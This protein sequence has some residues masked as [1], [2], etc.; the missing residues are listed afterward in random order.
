MSDGIKKKMTE[1]ELDALVD[2]MTLAQAAAAV[3]AV[4]SL[5]N[6]KKQGKLYGYSPQEHQVAI[7]ADKHKIVDIRGGNRCLGGEQLIY[8]PVLKAHRRVD[9]IEEDFHVMAW[10]GYREV[11]AKA[12]RPFQKAKAELY[13]LTFDDG[14]E[15]VVSPHHLLWG[16]SGWLECRL[17]VE[18][19]EVSV[20]HPASNWGTVPSV[21]PEDVEHSTCIT[22]GSRSYYRSHQHFCGGQLHKALASGPNTRPLQDDVLKHMPVYGLNLNFEPSDDRGDEPGYI[23]FYQNGGLLPSWDGPLHLLDLCAGIGSR[24]SCKLCGLAWG[25][26]PAFAQRFLGLARQPQSTAASGQQANHSLLDS[27]PCLG[28]NRQLSLSIPLDT[29]SNRSVVQI[30]YLRND[31]VWDFEVERYHNYF[32]GSILSHNSGKSE[33]SAYTMACHITGIY[34]SW[35]AGLTFSESFIYGVVS[36]STEQ[37]RKS[38]Q[39]KL[40]G[41]PHELGTG[42]IPKDLI[43]DYA[44]R[45]GTNGCLDWVLV[46]HASGGICRIEFMVCEQ[47]P[48]KFQGFAWKV[49]WF[50]EKPALPVFTEVQMRLIDNKGFIILSYFPSDDEDG[51][52]EMLDNMPADFCSHYEFH[53]EDNKT[54]DP[55]EIEMH[56]KTMPLWMQESRLYGRT[57]SGEGRI[58]TFNR[59]DYSVDPFEIEPMA[60]RIAGMDVGMAHG[61]AAVALALE[62]LSENEPPTIYVY[63]EYLRNGNLPGA[64]AI[65]LRSWGDIEFKIDPHSN[66]RSFS[67]GQRL[68]DMYREEGINV[69]KANAKPGSVLDS[70]NMINQA[71]AENR[72]YIFSS[73]RELLKQMGMYKMVKSKDG[74]VKVTEKNDDLVDCL[75]YAMMALDQAKS[76]GTTKITPMPRVAEW[77]PVNSRLGL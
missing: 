71:I 76:P 15:I 10:D 21:H 66:Q 30:E 5:N 68:F 35:W 74:R 34:P 33:S 29:T 72:L 42:Y 65:A 56:K 67:D 49:A 50:D 44:W 9:L 41:E 14:T 28:L 16:P 43:I 60:P 46:K 26:L 63:R 64:H 11:V 37:M 17:Y 38:A 32:I 40:M 19:L 54:L 39:V 20:P 24:I 55:A 69:T 48:S 73:C 59:D 4:E 57:G 36:V 25:S 7:H 3:D 6:K 58:F 62:Y 70:I 45:A 2:G 47:G 53:M 75:R 61:T 23:H 27:Y 51:L 18:K 22:Q 12:H 31:F 52:L 8:D 1:A 13:R 77:K